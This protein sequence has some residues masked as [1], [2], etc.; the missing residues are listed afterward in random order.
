MAT[1]KEIGKYCR[2]KKLYE[3]AKTTLCGFSNFQVFIDGDLSKLE[4]QAKKEGLDFF[5]LKGE[6]KKPKTEEVK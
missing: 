5:V 3:K 4:A 1:Q 6:L 2:D